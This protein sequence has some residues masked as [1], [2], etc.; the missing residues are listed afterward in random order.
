MSHPD[1]AAAV[2][3]F[4]AEATALGPTILALRDE[5]ERE[6]RIPRTLVEALRA[7]GFFSLWLA[8]AHGGPELDLAGFVRVVE[9]LARF[10]AS[11]AWCVA[12]AGGYSRFSGFLPEPVARR[13]FVEQRVA[14][15]GA[16]G[17]TGR[18]EPVPGGY[19]VSGRWP[20]GSGLPH[21]DW[22]LAGCTVWEGDAPRR[23]AQGAPDT[24]VVFFPVEQAEVIDTWHV[25]GLRGTGSHDY[26]VRD[27][28]VPEDHATAGTDPLVPGTLYAL[29]WRTP[30]GVAIAAVPL[31]IARAAL[32]AAKDL[33][34]AKT[35]RQGSTV[36]R[37]RPVV[38][39]AIGRAEAMLRGARAFLLEACD[40]IWEGVSAGAAATLEQRAA[41]RL[42]CA[43][44]AEATKAVAQ[45]A[46]EIGGGTA[47]YESCPIQRCFRDVHAA[48]QHVQIQPLGFETGGRVL[49]GL[50]PG[51]PI[52]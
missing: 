52:F 28:F 38:Q 48:A 16:L 40:E 17:P 31:G 35:P 27:L 20:Y 1:P 23:T 13:L 3:R 30:F 34:M 42:A 9:A 43:Q 24:R 2:S 51:S 12:N 37:D 47:V 44:V 29:P 33:A 15:A 6:R 50:D 32:D 5:I 21:C 39:A 4:L 25:G 49:L 19:R 11:V 10:D 26:Q 7:R 14:I 45:T 18:A 41:V 22:V 8:R 46:Y 36:L